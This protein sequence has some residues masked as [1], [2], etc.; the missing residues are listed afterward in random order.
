[1]LALA[2]TGFLVG[3]RAASSEL[4]CRGIVQVGRVGLS[5]PINTFFVIND[6]FEVIPVSKASSAVCNRCAVKL[7]GGRIFIGDAYNNR[8]L[9]DFAHVYRKFATRI[10]GVFGFAGENRRLH[11]RAISLYEKCLIARI[12]IP[13]LVYVLPSPK[14]IARS[15]AQDQEAGINN[16]LARG[17]ISKIANGYGEGS[18]PHVNRWIRMFGLPGEG[19][20]WRLVLWSADKMKDRKILESNI[21]GFNLYPRSTL[22]YSKLLIHGIELPVIYDRQSNPYTHG[23]CFENHLPQWSHVGLAIAGLFVMFFGWIN[24]RKGRREAFSL[25]AFLLGCVTWGYS[26]N[27]LIGWSLAC[28]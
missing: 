3:V 12:F 17:N 20:F 2:V 10:N 27:W 24:L 16:R 26:V 14:I 22:H 15:F 25:F 5:V 19:N 7:P 18:S 13:I 9:K 6:M 4:F 8:V 28:G 1:M 11:A 21:R 23:R